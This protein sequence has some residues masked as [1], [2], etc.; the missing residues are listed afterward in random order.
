MCGCVRAVGSVP[1]WHEIYMLPLCTAT[2]PLYLRRL[3]YLYLVVRNWNCKHWQWK[4]FVLL[5]LG[6]VSLPPNSLPYKLCHRDW[7]NG[8]GVIN[9]CCA[10]VKTRVF[11]SQRPANSPGILQTNILWVNSERSKALFWPPHIHRHWL[12]LHVCVHSHPPHTHTP[13]ASG[14]FCRDYGVNFRCHFVQFTLTWHLCTFHLHTHLSIL[15]LLPTEPSI[16][17]SSLGQGSAFDW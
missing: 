9:V 1:G 10:I 5:L 6:I 15:A 13:C 17:F 14:C 11:A 4:S 3:S 2:N 8:S 16:C 12:P 7:R